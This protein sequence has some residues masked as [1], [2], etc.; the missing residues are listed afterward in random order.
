V[1]EIQKWA[2]SWVTLLDSSL[3]SPAE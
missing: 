3:Q 1:L 2:T